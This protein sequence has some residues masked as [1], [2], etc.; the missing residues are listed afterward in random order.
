MTMPAS[1]QPGDTDMGP[2]PEPA[3]APPGSTDASPE[4]PLSR[5]GDSHTLVR[6]AVV[7]VLSVAAVVLAIVA[8]QF[9]R[10]ADGGGTAAAAVQN[11]D[12]SAV[13]LGIVG[14]GSTKIGSQAPLFQLPSP[15]GQVIRLSDLRGKVVLI[16]FWATWC[17]PCRREIPDLVNL[18]T[19]WGDGVQIVGVD[20]QETPDDV[21]RYAEVM[22]MNYP[23]ALDF[24]GEVASSYK[25]KGLPTTFF[26]DGQGVIRDLRI[27]ILSPDLARC[28]VSGIE[29]GQHNPSDCR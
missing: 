22:Q 2:E 19:E 14:D 16:N 11:G 4:S 6:D 24:N 20:L 29:R 3:P 18:Q 9:I 10:K 13:K 25:I 8:V 1:P 26:L 15:Y 12:Y 5:R 27:G 17:V 7:S 28:I 21:V 23:L